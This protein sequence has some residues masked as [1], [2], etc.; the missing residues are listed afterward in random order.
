MM[1]RIVGRTLQSALVG[2]SCLALLTAF[3]CTK[4]EPVPVLD[5]GVNSATEPVTPPAPSETAS[6]PMAVRP[7]D[8]EPDTVADAGSEGGVRVRRRLIAER[9]AGVVETLAAAPP[10][11]PTPTADPSS[12][13][14]RGK[15][16][17]APMG[18]EQPYGTSAASAAPALT[19]T[20]LPD[21]DPWKRSTDASR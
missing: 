16:L 2:V 4:N 17:A 18:N 11:P 12:E 14:R 19:K 9:D 10:T 20:R 3:G 5:A 8:E 7:P 6:T 15:H 21:E 13:P 1:R